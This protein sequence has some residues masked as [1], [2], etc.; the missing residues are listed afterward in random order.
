MSSPSRGPLRGAP[1][2]RKKQRN[3]EVDCAWEPLREPGMG[4]PL[5]AIVT[6]TSSGEIGPRSLTGSSDRIVMA[7]DFGRRG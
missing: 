5:P 7:D 1:G 3:L 4:Q 6:G 2:L